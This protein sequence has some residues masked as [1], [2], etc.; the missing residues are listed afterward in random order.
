[1]LINTLTTDLEF[2]VVNEVVA[3]PV[4]PTELSTR[5]V[6]GEELNLRESGLEVHTVDQVTVALDSARDLLAEV[7]RTIE[8]VLNG[9]HGEVSVSA[10]DNLE[11]GDLGV[12]SQVNVLSAIRDELH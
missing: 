11:E 7:G 9:L 12:T 6:R 10:V 3:N 5:A 4:E 1:V 8:G 2:N